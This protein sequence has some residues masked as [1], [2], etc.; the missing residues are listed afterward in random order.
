MLEPSVVE[1]GDR[2]RLSQLP[3]YARE[4]LF[5][6]LLEKLP[7]GAYT[8]DADGLIT[9]YN[10]QAVR[11]WGRAPALN[12]PVD[13]FCGS[14]R[15]YA[16]D[17]TPI[18]HGECWM[19]LALR[20]DREYNGA[21]LIVERP[22]GERL[23]VLAHAAPIH[24]ESG[25]LIGAVNV[26]VDISDRKR[27]E[28]ALREADRAK[29][30]FLATMSH[31]I[32]TPLNAIIGYADLLE[33]EIAGPLTAR[34][35]GHLGRIQAACR[36]LV[37]LLTEVLDLSKVEA[38]KMVIRREPRRTSDVVAAALAVVHPL[39]AGKGVV[40]TRQCDAGAPLE[41]VGDED[42]VRQML[43]NLLSNAIKYSEPGGRVEIAC[44][45]PEHPA[46]TLASDGAPARWTRLL[47]RDAGIGIPADQLERIFEPFVQVEGSRT[48]GRGGTGLGLTITRRLARLMGGDITV[49]STLGQ[50]SLFSLWLPR[51]QERAPRAPSA[52]AHGDD[53]SPFGL[54][55]AAGHALLSRID[56]VLRGYVDRLRAEH[57]GRGARALS[58]AQLANHA[59][60][61]LSHIA[62]TLLALDD[63]YA[64]TTYTAGSDVLRVCA[65]EHGRQRGQLGWREEELA[66]EYDV[67]WEEIAR[68]MRS[69]AA[70]SERDRDRVLA[71]VR[72]RVDQARAFSLQGRR[73]IIDP[74]WDSITRE[75]VP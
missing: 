4:P 46:A 51:S 3:V 53:A 31:E 54:F 52:P 22:G 19:A 55:S 69:L 40:L 70:P 60:T 11:L 7:A 17:G 25:E 26:L 2:E 8:C 62:V 49:E 37:S 10:P 71:A 28:E 39:A 30:D 67:L 23:T 41:Y 24:D 57:A 1:G 48:R 66:R 72:A 18:D 20:M 74:R 27:A 45:A 59:A 47:V 21:E 33:L 12:D 42:R 38:G 58:R 13:R 44:D 64:G 29:S 6:H 14:F 68:C 63:G 5:R 9:Y 73:S 56:E 34:Q 32:R 36:H 65:G 75:G 50:G 35:R 15:L 43:I 16:S 61:L